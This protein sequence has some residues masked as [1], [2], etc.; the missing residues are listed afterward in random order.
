M[1]FSELAPNWDKKLKKASMFVDIMEELGS[2]NT[3]II[4]EITTKLGLPVDKEPRKNNPDIVNL[5][6]KCNGCWQLGVQSYKT[7]S[8]GKPYLITPTKIKD[9]INTFYKII[10]PKIEQHMKAEHNIG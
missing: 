9:G 1:K 8:G 10:S 6:P 7:I 2:F 3:C 4:G 5:I